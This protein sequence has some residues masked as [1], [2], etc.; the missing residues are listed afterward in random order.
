MPK[1]FVHGNPETSAIWSALFDALRDK[2]IDD[3]V[4]LS[5]PGFGA[6]L[7][8]GFEATQTGYRNWLVQELEQLG[9]DIDLVGHD[10]GTGHVLGVLAQRPDLLRSWATTS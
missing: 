4:G 10:W 2:G 5:P 3:L 7:P 8:T 9:G 6:P 1:V